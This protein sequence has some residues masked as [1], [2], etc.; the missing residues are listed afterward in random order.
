[1][2]AVDFILLKHFRARP[3]RPFFISEEGHSLLRHIKSNGSR[4][5]SEDRSQQ[6][7]AY[8]K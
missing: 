8:F 7:A 2:A 5:P 3:A 4:G 1:M 6:T